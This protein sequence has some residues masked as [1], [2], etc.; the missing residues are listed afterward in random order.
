MSVVAI[1]KR[2]AHALLIEAK[3]TQSEDVLLKDFALINAAI[4]HS[5]DL[6][7]LLRSPI[8]ESWRKKNVIREIFNS[9][10]S[11]LMLKFLLLVVDK[12]REQFIP[13]IATTFSELVD[14]ERNIT[15]VGVT[16][17]HEIDAD[18]QASLTKV[19]SSRTKST[20]EATY[21]TDSSLLGGVTVTVGDTVIDGS[22]RHRLQELKHR[23]A[24]N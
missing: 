21:K 24:N 14:T 4:S 5:A 12:R 16:S 19:L 9:T 7:M 3:K 11:E 13:E 6:R 18:S 8:I 22:L 2:Y 10:V 15:R 1:A 23:L 17:A 20:V